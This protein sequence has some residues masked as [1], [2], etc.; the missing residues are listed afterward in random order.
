ML[1]VPLLSRIADH[2]R[3]CGIRECCDLQHASHTRAL[4]DRPRRPARDRQLRDRSDGNGGVR[5]VRAV[6]RHDVHALFD[7]GCDALDGQGR[8]RQRVPVEGLAH[9]PE[10]RPVL[11]PGAAGRDRP[12]GRRHVSG[13]HDA[14]FRR[15][16]PAVLVR[17]L[18][19][20]GPRR[21]ERQQPG[22]AEPARHA[23]RQRRPLR[24]HDGRQR[25]PVRAARR[26]TAISSKWA[27]RWARSSVRASGPS[28]GRRCRSS[29]PSA[30]T[31]SAA[32]RTPT[33]RTGRRTSPCRASGGRYANDLYCCVNGTTATNYASAWYAFN[34]GRPASTCS[35]SAWGDTN[36][37]T[38]SV[39][40]NDYAAH[41][42]PGTPE[43][44]W[45]L[46]DL[47]RTRPASSSR[48]R[49]TRSTRTTRARAPTR[50]SRA[51]AR[52]RAC[53]RSTA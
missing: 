4:S 46:A 39:Y 51:R 26:T 3:T 8:K 45:L 9:V 47:Q 40:A 53:S 34:A 24:R 18:R 36:P 17:R 22:S 38:A 42:A 23:R 21:R 43:Y 6:R 33:S 52:S 7:A 30:T 41:F 28:R 5:V 2:V 25:L 12:A 27:R 50:S 32:R 16:D 11:L 37:G 14:G 13:D 49:T 48:S 31:A 44:P 15:V 19:R 20:L 10:R 35:T 29:R 1:K